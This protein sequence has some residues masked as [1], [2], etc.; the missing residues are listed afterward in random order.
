LVTFFYLDRP[1]GYYIIYMQ[2]IEV[3]VPTAALHCTCCGRAQAD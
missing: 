2:L 3:F 1:N